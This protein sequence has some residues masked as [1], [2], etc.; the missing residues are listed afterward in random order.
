MAHDDEPPGS[1]RGASARCAG[2]Q[3]DPQLVTTF[4]EQVYPALF[5]A[6]GAEPEGADWLEPDADVAR[7]RDVSGGVA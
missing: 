2:T 3:F 6:D 1:A 5:E 4:C 7:A